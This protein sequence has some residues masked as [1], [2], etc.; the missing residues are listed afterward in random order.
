MD[1]PF[2]DTNNFQVP[3]H[4]KDVG[5]QDRHLCERLYSG[6]RA[7]GSSTQRSRERIV[8]DHER[9]ESLKISR[10]NSPSTERL[11]PEP[12]LGDLCLSGGAMALLQ[13]GVRGALIHWQ[14]RF[15]HRTVTNTFTIEF[16]PEHWNVNLPFSIRISSGIPL[17]L[18][19][20]C[21]KRTRILL[22]PPLISH[23]I[24]SNRL[25]WQDNSSRARERD[26]AKQRERTVVYAWKWAS[27]I[28][29]Y[30]LDERWP[31]TDWQTRALH[32]EH[33]STR[34]TPDWL[35]GRPVDWLDWIDAGYTRRLLVSILTVDSSAE[36]LRCLVFALA[37]ARFLDSIES[38]AQEQRLACVYLRFE[39]T[40]FLSLFCFL[41]FFFWREF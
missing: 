10:V 24:F 7:R 32:L 22:L 11:S 23:F 12:G 5:N 38:S 28:Q 29:Q 3:I 17:R 1:E 21:K 19:F 9:W 6:H 31:N 15:S 39:R 18:A 35:I 30:A 14:T 41:F 4:K 40:S 13:T 37:H 33:R 36:L 16:V 27:Y 34:V 26:H 20:D 25:K 2:L 8:N